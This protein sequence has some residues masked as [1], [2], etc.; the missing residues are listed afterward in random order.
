MVKNCFRNNIAGKKSPHLFFFHNFVV[1]PV[2]VRG[3]GGVSGVSKH[4]LFNFPY[5]VISELDNIGM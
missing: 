1:F 3:E 5:V 4:V 2:G